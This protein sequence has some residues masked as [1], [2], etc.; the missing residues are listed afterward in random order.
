VTPEILSIICG[1]GITFLAMRI[2][3]CTDAHPVVSFLHR[4]TPMK[5]IQ[6]NTMN[7]MSMPLTMTIKELPEYYTGFQGKLCSGKS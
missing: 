3:N 2:L 1:A 6:A 5:G 7:P 4:I